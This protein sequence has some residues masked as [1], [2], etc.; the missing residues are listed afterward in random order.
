MPAIK[1]SEFFEVEKNW[2]VVSTKEE[3]HKVIIEEV[4]NEKRENIVGEIKVG[5]RLNT[6]INN[7]E[8]AK[9][10]RAKFNAKGLK[11]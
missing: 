9:S 5:E 11:R 6:P 8:K 10:I 1:I 2:I 7:L 4:L 3:Q